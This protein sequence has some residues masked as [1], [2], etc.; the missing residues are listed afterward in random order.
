MDRPLLGGHL[1]GLL[2]CDRDPFRLRRR[3]GAL[4]QAGLWDAQDGDRRVGQRKRTVGSPMAWSHLPPEHFVRAAEALLGLFTPNAC[5]AR[6]T[7]G[8][9]GQGN[10]SML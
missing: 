10:C 3:A 4:R 5:S 2:G 6:Y 8:L 9:L 1:L 7:G